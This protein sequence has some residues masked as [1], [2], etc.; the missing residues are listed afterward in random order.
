VIKPPKNERPATKEQNLHI[1]ESMIYINSYLA[2]TPKHLFGF[3]LVTNSFLAYIRFVVS[4]HDQTLL[5]QSG[6]N[7]D[8]IKEGSKSSSTISPWRGRKGGSS[9]I[10]F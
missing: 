8:E 4:P 6:H 9:L 2:L 7:S 1:D 3:V 5:G 10:F